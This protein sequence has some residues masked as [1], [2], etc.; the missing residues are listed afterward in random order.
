MLA[1][2]RILHIED[3]LLDAELTKA[4]LERENIA[5][6]ITPAR[7]AKEFQAALE[8]D[9]YD[10]V[11]CDFNLPSFDGFAALKQCREKLPHT[12]FIF[13]SGTIGEE[14]A[15]ESLKNGATDYV[16]KQNINRL[17]SSIR[18]AI[19]E[20]ELE[21]QRAAIEERLLRSEQLYRTI[22]ES[23]G[24]AMALI[25]AD[26]TIS[27]VNSTFAQIAGYSREEIEG[28]KK[29]TEFV[30]QE[31]LETMTGYHVL[32]RKDPT[33]APSSYQ[34]RF[35]DRRGE[36]QE[37]LLTISVIPGT[38]TS[39]ASMIDITEQR[40]LERE[41]I[42]NANRYRSLFEGSPDAVVLSSLD[43][44]VILC[45][46]QTALL[47]GYDDPHELVGRN[48]FDFVVPE[49]H[50]RAK[51]NAQQTLTN[52]IV[53]SFEY[54]LIRKDGLRI[55]VEG[56]SSLIV[57]AD[58]SPAALTNV[59]R[60]IRERREREERI[61]EQAALLDVDPDA[62]IVRDMDD[63]VIFW[64][65]GAETMYGWKAE[66]VI[67][68]TSWERLPGEL[69]PKY[70]KAKATLLE[71]GEWHG[72]WTH[73][74]KYGRDIIVSS[75]WKLVRDERGQPKN[76]YVVNT[77]ITE[78]KK[79]ELQFLRAQRLE[80]IG[81]LAGGIAHDLNNVLGPVLMAV[82]ILRRKLT[83]EQSQRL[84]DNLE[85]SAKRGADMVKQVLTFARGVEGDQVLLQPKHLIREVVSM[86]KD[87]FPKSITLHENVAK[88]LHTITGDATQIHQML[89]NLCIN[90]RDAMPNGGTLTI[91]AENVV[92]DEAFAKT[93]LLTAPGEYVLIKVSDTGTGIP[94]EI[95]DKIFDPFFTTKEHGKGTGL[96]LSTTMGI[97]K[98]HKGCINVYSEV[99]HGTEF[100]IYLPASESGIQNTSRADQAVATTSGSGELVLVID[101]ESAIREITRTTLES[102]G[103]RVLLAE[104]G[105]QA[106]GLFAK[107]V[108]EIRVVVT[109]MMMP[110]MDGAATIRA[111]LSLRPDIRIV[112]MSGLTD[113]S[114]V[115]MLARAGQITFLQKPFT[116]DRLLSS[117]A[118]ALKATQQ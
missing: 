111:M 60:D 109:D 31:D 61:G 91:S 99:G 10:L 113:N 27:L 72:E 101:D 1:P 9:R 85:T 54:T 5:C 96:G 93:H 95:Q 108:D 73:K 89:M 39:V 25:E 94:E 23:T 90:A 92:V 53:K 55:P 83:D 14:T 49:D 112:A 87:T 4:I 28:K 34:F 12:P 100:H 11:L 50:E 118:A 102:D 70:D 35:K 115:E 88:D 84:L 110:H 106:L 24:T 41:L 6:T 62:I 104:D 21:Q 13:L 15:I 74:T 98:G 18:R 32:R 48:I 16:L 81:T 17:G 45:N 19:R 66:E 65:K 103:F 117:V 22:F 76:V 64:S 116:A 51:L 114:R 3:D 33:S 75:V 42:T 63:R 26:T 69:R 47:L 67:G 7:S 58:G 105:T 8:T 79:L 40:R 43:A 71:Q 86:C 57:K 107:H 97:V 56:S 44:K 46:R 20:R 37:V 78:R 30:A 38:T 68:S 29:W 59:L 2:L 77:D 80:S 36:V 82:S 52:G